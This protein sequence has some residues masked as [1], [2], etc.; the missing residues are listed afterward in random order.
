MTGGFVHFAMLWGLIG[1]AIPVVI[2]LL[3]R[4]RAV[5]I[6]WGAMQF[7][8]I[9]RRARRKFQITELLLMMGRMLLLGLVA[10][11]LARPFW[12]PKEVA[13]APGGGGS[14][15]GQRRDVVLVLDGSESMDRRG[16]GTTPRLQALKWARDFVGRLNPGDSVALLVAGD[17]V[18]PI[19]APPTF[20][21]ARIEEAIKKAPAARGSSDLP[22]AL[23]EAFRLLEGTQNPG[24][25][26]VILTD[27]QRSAW[28]AGEARR[29][30]LLPRPAIAR[31]P[32]RPRIWSVAFNAGAKSEGADGA[33]EPLEL[34][35]GLVSPGL[36]VSVSTTIRNAGPGPMTRTAELLVDGVL[37]PGSARVVGPIPPGGKSPVGFRAT[38]AA[39]GS[40]VVSVRLAPDDDPLPGNDRADRPIE[41]TPAL[42]VL[43]VDGEPGS[44]PLSGEVDFLRAALAPTG[45]DTPQV[46]AT[47]VKTGE[48]DAGALEG[49]AVVVLANVDRLSPAQMTALNAFLGRGGGLVVAPGDRTDLA[50]WNEYAYQ[51]G[52][53]LLPARLGEWK[54]DFSRR[55]AVAHPAPR[56]FSGPALVPFGQAEDA[57][58]READLFSF[59]VLKPTTRPPAGRGDGAAGFG[60]P[61]DRRAA[62]AQGARRAARRAVGRGGG[63]PAGESGLRPLG[64]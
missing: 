28:R 1:L 6:D 36:P 54:G 64:P 14:G 13:A 4:R 41:V 59:W 40:H 3:N 48:L 39:P 10:L 32:V 31:M 61:V 25:D 44:E 12:K 23:A 53:G 57:P 21:R 29:W 47:V 15:A 33:V 2:H 9:G 26:V 5:V 17:R 58:L 37:E 60:G 19:V 27:G 63:H 43:L 20:D 30:A 45:D 52:R 46:K 16:D 55:E 24:R 11:A 38:I 35:R 56:S 49:Q 8:E 62:R 50:Y 18:R 34:S 7:L 42:P 22:A 51:D